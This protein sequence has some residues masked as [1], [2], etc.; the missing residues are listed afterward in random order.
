M[1]RPM[2]NARRQLRRPFSS[3]KPLARSVA[4][5][6]A[7]SISTSRIPATVAALPATGCEGLIRLLCGRMNAGELNHIKVDG[8]SVAYRIT[9]TGPPLV[10]LHGLL[11][12][13][14][15]WRSH[16]TGLADQFTLVAWDA[17]GA[18]SSSDPPE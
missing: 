8:L 7:A 11:C 17:P 5:D 9:G 16:L 10:L 12:D 1:S 14:R 2:R 4:S 15:C 18:G 13:S 6:N 3:G